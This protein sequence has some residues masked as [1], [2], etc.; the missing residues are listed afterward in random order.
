[1]RTRNWIWG[2]SRTDD[3]R[4][5]I[6]SSSEV[7]SMIEKAKTIAAKEKTGEFKSQWER[8]QLSAALKNEEHRGCTQAISSIASW[9][10]G[11]ADES[12]MYKKHKM[13][14]IMHNTEEIFAQQFFNFMRKNP[15]YVVRMNIP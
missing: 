13:Q 7:T 5:L 9:K 15:Q 2:R 4:Q 6:T 8:D 11:F 10:E 12:H 14:E 3:S 1:V